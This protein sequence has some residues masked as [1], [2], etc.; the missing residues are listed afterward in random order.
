MG[1]EMLD[2]RASGGRCSVLLTAWRNSADVLITLAKCLWLL[3]AIVVQYCSR[4]VRLRDAWIV[5]IFATFVVICLMLVVV[6]GAPAATPTEEPAALSSRVHELASEV[7]RVQKTT[8]SV[9]L[10]ITVLIGI[11]AA[12]GA[13]GIVF[14]FRD[15]RRTS[16]LHELT[17][18]GELAT[19]RRAEQGYASFFEQSQ[20]TL[21]LVNDTLKLAKEANEEAART[22]KSKAQSRADEIEERAQRLMFD[23]FHE[24]EFEV[25]IKDPDRLRVLETVADEL[26]SLEGYLSVQEVKL[27]HYTR[28]IGAIDKFI[29]DDTEGALEALEL[30][31]Q[32]GV[33][34]ELQRFTEYWLGYMLTTVGEYEEA[35]SRF[36][37]DELDLDHKDPEYFQL[38]RIIAETDFFARAKS[39]SKDEEGSITEDTRSPRQRFDAVFGVLERLAKLKLE[40]DTSGDDRAKTDTQLDVARTRADIFEWIAYDPRHLD[41]P[42]PAAAIVAVRR[43]DGSVADLHEFNTSDEWR[44]VEDPDRVRAWALVQAR[45]ICEEPTER[46]FDV[47]FALAECLF[48]LGERKRADMVFDKAEHLAH[49]MVGE[50]HEQRT[51]AS[52]HES[53]LI[54]HV[55]L[56]GLHEREDEKATSERRQV[57]QASRSAQEAVGQL[58]QGRVTVFS[59]IQRRNISQEAFKKEIREIV[60]QG[61]VDNEVK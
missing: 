45:Q 39:K 47:E 49:E 23:V 51:I 4:G 10:P 27:H 7:D 21:S 52:L 31:S 29:N 42:L 56:F 5:R 15:Q 9:F 41:D 36:K 50:Q 19:Q 17:V 57:L 32:A 48:K 53:L 25:I 28:F 16:Q 54:C 14:S 12:G 20:T 43:G 22:M 59:Q 30:L 37:H 18:Q 26:R 34:G 13:L 38:E 35:V 33:V 40:I 2:W 24:R 11:L 6:P 46:N 44:N 60:N 1:G 3:P 61:R 55:R 8:N 58:R